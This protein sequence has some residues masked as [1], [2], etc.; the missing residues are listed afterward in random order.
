MGIDISKFSQEQQVILNALDKNKDGII[1]KEND[2]IDEAS[3]G[4]LLGTVEE[5][6][7]GDT[8]TT[9]VVTK[10]ETPAPVKELTGN[11]AKGDKAANVGHLEQM[12]RK[13]YTREQALKELSDANVYPN[14]SPNFK[15][16]VEVII[17]NMSQADSSASV[18]KKHKDTLKNLKNNAEIKKLNVDEDYL[19]D[20]LEQLE[21]M[22][23]RECFMAKYNEVDQAFKKGMAKDPNAEVLEMDPAKDP[24]QVMND[25]KARVKKAKKFH[26]DF[27]NAFKAYEKDLVKG[28]LTSIVNAMNKV[29]EGV[30]G[31]KKILKATDEIMEGKDGHL[32]KYSEKALY[33]STTRI[34]KAWNKVRGK[35]S[36]G[37]ELADGEERFR[38]VLAHKTVT[39]QEVDKRL[40]KGDASIEGLSHKGWVTEKDGKWDLSKFIDL[41]QDMVGTDN[42]LNRDAKKDAQTAERKLTLDALKDASGLDISEDDAI[43]LVK[44]CGIKV[45]GKNWKKAIIQALIGGASGAALTSGSTLI[46]AQRLKPIQIPYSKEKYYDI[47]GELQ[48]QLQNSI[49]KDCGV[50]IDASGNIHIL[51]DM[52]IKIPKLAGQLGELAV[53]S[54]IPGALVGAALGMARGLED[55]G[56]AS[57]ISVNFK[58]KTYDEYINKLKNSTQEYAPVAILLADSFVDNKGNWDREG[59]LAFLNEM[60]GDGNDIINKQELLDGL[61]KR[62]KQL[63][64]AAKT[65]R[66]EGSTNT[67]QTTSNTTDNCGEKCNVGVKEQKGEET[68]VVTDRTFVH[69]RKDNPGVGWKEMVEAYFPGLVEACGGLYGPNG[70]IKAFQREL[71]TDA[72][73]KF[74]RA[75]FVELI[76][77]TDVPREI[78]IP[79][80]VKGIDR[81][82]TKPTPAG[83]VVPPEEGKAV[84]AMDK[85]GRDEKVTIKKV[86][87]STYLATD[88]CNG[89]TASGT[90]QKEAV[91]NL[92]KQE[93]KQYANR[94]EFLR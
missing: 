6:K 54:A 25:I 22:Q 29:D 31:G 4:A 57:T 85:V 26:G 80:Q 53:Y 15:K 91:E 36:L 10:T 62:Q 77:A 69:K 70:A 84:A 41:V 78:K 63:D 71:C 20:I 24:E 8:Y 58:E 14:L 93:K 55:P 34:G 79:L 21:N 61:A 73:G 89:H 30:R 52:F 49:P 43:A 9:N 50:T 28:S 51:V 67:E 40:G 27:E 92:E 68:L 56:Q 74:D 3:I 72:E 38:N 32:D 88:E 37:R 44:L 94:D 90:S 83:Q 18:D 60:A 66:P 47:S 16:L 82:E 46:A 48:D 39:Q 19:K 12:S 2:G 1:D 81:V 65:Q 42:T 76:K 59:Y 86:G 17:N 13:G 11:R 87:P 7:P 35:K 45:E 64:E 33:G 75:K 23:K 5:N